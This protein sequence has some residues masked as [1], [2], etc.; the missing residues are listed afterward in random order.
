MSQVKRNSLTTPVSLRIALPAV[1][2]VILFATAIFIIILPALESSLL[3]RKKEMIRELTES[4]WSI[5]LS[6]EQL[7]QKGVLTLD[8]AQKEAIHHVEELRY[9]PEREDYF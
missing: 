5:L 7:H 6:H 4:A 9:G 1:L 3:A 8:E 2:T